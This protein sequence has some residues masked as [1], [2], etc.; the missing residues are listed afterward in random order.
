M[1]D[2]KTTINIDVGGTFTDGFFTDGQKIATAKVPTTSHELT[3]G[4]IECIEIGADKLGMEI[5]SLLGKADIVRFSTTMGTNAIIEKKGMCIGLLVTAGQENKLYSVENESNVVDFFVGRD[6]VE[7]INEEVDINGKL[8]A[9]PDIKQTLSA[10]KKLQES[11]ARMIVVALKNSYQNNSNEKLVKKIIQK[12]YPRH[13]LG[14]IPTLASFEVS[15]RP[16]DYR[17]LNTVVVNAYIHRPMKVSLYRAEDKI[18]SLLYNKPLFIGHSSGGVGGLAK[19]RAIDTLNSGPVAGVFGVK[20]LSETYQT[21]MIGADMGGTSLDLSI[22]KNKELP[23]EL[24]HIVETLPTH[25]PAITVKTVGIGGGSIAKMENG[26]L[27]VGPESVGG[28]PGPACFGRGGK[29]ATITDADVILGKISSDFFLGGRLELST[30]LSKKSFEDNIVGSRKITVEDAALEVIEQVGLNIRNAIGEMDTK[31]IETIVAY[32]GA[33]PMHMTEL[34]KYNQ[35]KRIIVTPHS[36]VFSAFGESMMGVSHIYTRPLIDESDVDKLTR[37]MKIEAGKDMLIEGFSAD[38]IKF[39]IDL[40]NYD[41]MERKDSFTA[42]N[43]GEINDGLVTLRLHA[44]GE[45][46]RVVFASGKYESSDP[47]SAYV[48]DREVIWEG[49]KIMTPV[50]LFEKLQRGAMI[51]GPAIVESSDT[52]IPIVENTVFM[53]DSMGNGI[54]GSKKK[55]VMDFSK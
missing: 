9:E 20:S 52:T 50:F 24:S 26:L 18:R 4:F 2:N 37:E 7:G 33:G 35:I 14:S 41:P 16:D 32:G 48:K 31:G 10:I 42:L 40:I 47:S 3:I 34:V 36:S 6:M 54:I 28:N 30:D 29:M 11:G 13:Y 38:E 53:I 51:E 19:T 45:V 17:R 27:R 43:A 1:G 46:G 25:I 39:D 55:E 49:D 12:E 23:F 5:S 21:D 44:S 8:I 22:V 15:S